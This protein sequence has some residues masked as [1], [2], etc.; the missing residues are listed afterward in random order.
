M[1]DGPGVSPLGAVDARALAARPLRVF[2]KPEAG[3]R[4]DLLELELRASP[5]GTRCSTTIE[6]CYGD[7][8]IFEGALIGG[9]PLR[10]CWS[11]AGP[12]LDPAAFRLS[13]DPAM[14]LEADLTIR[15]RPISPGER[16]ARLGEAAEIAPEDWSP[17]AEDLI[18]LGRALG[19]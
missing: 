2:L 7:A 12:R 17:R 14:A 9:R 19:A 13:A 11:Q 15:S 6:L 16:Q 4:V 8:V 1:R 5:P 18:A 10:R 3:R